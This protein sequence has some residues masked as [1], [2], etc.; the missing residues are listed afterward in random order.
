MQLM[1]EI[2][3]GK[4]TI[5]PVEGKPLERRIF[6]GEGM[7]ARVDLRHDAEV[8]TAWRDENGKSTTQG[9]PVDAIK[10]NLRMQ[11]MANYLITATQ[12]YIERT[13]RG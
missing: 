7:V 10:A 3:P 6:V 9:L 12:R 13:P 5:R 11:A 1:L 2:N 8:R 4:V